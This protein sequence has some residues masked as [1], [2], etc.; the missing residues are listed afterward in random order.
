MPTSGDES[1]EEG[2]ERPGAPADTTGDAPTP[3]SNGAE[4][5]SA[6][7][8]RSLGVGVVAGAM[9]GLFGVGGGIVIVPLLVALAAF[10]QRRAHATSLA[11]IGLVAVSGTTGYALDGEVDWAV[12]ALMAAG[13][14][15]GAVLGTH[16]LRVLPQRQLQLAFAAVLALTAVRLVVGDTAEGGGFELHPLSGA[17]IVVL[18][19]AVGVLAGVL[20]IGGGVLSVPVLTILAGMPLVLAKGTSLAVI[21]P[22]SIVG[23]LRNRRAGNVDGRAAVLVG[24]GGVVS[25]F[26]AA[27]VSLGLDP[28]VSSWLFAALLA[29]VAIRMGR[30]ALLSKGP[31]H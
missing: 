6:A 29:V 19:V 14:I 22:T 5:S 11:A 24:L 20:G 21:I 1:S 17:G 15:G 25:A 7:T 4:A 9:S 10:D 16:L 12:A 18:G 27:R 13:S 30:S 8:W 3:S 23:T 2:Q 31:G 28:T 26:L